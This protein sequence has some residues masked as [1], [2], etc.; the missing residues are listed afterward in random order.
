MPSKKTQNRY[1]VDKS[2]K[3]CIGVCFDVGNDKNLIPAK[4]QE[5]LLIRVS[6]VTPIYIYLLKLNRYYF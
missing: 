4:L 6:K 5:R 3:F 2:N 1:V